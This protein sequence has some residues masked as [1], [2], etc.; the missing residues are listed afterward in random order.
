MIQI[1]PIADS[2]IPNIIIFYYEWKYIARIKG[3]CKALRSISM[4]KFQIIRNV[5][6]L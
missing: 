5:F 1:V 2:T 3:V 6:Q 4:H